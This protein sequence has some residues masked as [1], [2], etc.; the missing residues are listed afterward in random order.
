MAQIDG[1][2]GFWLL[3][4]KNG[5]AFVTMKIDRLNRVGANHDQR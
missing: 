1:S 2:G 3:L 5:V 4:A